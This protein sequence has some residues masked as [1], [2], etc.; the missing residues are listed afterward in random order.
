MIVALRN[1]VVATG[2]SI[3]VLTSLSTA[4][5]AEQDWR[6][7]CTPDAEVEILIGGS[8][9]RGT[10]AGPDING[11][12]YCDVLNTSYTGR[13]MHF[14]MAPDR[15]RA[16]QLMDVAGPGVGPAPTR[17]D[18]LSPGWRALCIP[19]DE[20]EI[21][22]GSAWHK[23]IVA[24]P[25]AFGDEACGV[26]NT[27]YSGREM[28]FS[29]AP[30]RMRA[31]NSSAAGAGG[32]TKARPRASQTLKANLAQIGE[33]YRTNV[34]AARQR[35]EGLT[36]TLSGTLERAGS[37]YVRLTDGPF[38]EAMCTFNEADRH[39]LAELIPG[40]K[41]TVQGDESSWGWD[42][43][44]LVGCRVIGEQA[45]SPAQGAEPVF[46]YGGPPV[47]RYVCRQ[48]MTTIGWVDLN[49]GTYGV[50]G[51]QGTY[52]FDLGTGAIVW[53]DGAYRGWPAWFEYSP[54]GSGHAHDE[55]I[56]RMTDETD[57]LR[58][59]CFLTSE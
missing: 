50:N 44:Q 35:Y 9:Y 40:S 6:Q 1:S 27:S 10:V 55:Y 51:V 25:D 3:V 29:M 11:E 2:L 54:A 47:G 43:F 7:I 37:D 33:A 57:T 34:A 30:D 31:I 16:V 4:S 58:I 13:D 36:V 56:I 22:V 12:P 38:G 39:H 46:T 32:K 5:T 24:S 41:L 28:L 26:L 18:A 42:T 15:M 23:G 21:L 17:S 19:G 53:Q 52:S 14:S 49:E 20:V 45:M 8:W 59:D 48:Y